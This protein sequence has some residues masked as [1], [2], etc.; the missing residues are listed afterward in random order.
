VASTSGSDPMAR[1]LSSR[2]IVDLQ[3]PPTP[4]KPRVARRLARRHREVSQRQ[5]PQ[6]ATPPK[7]AS[8]PA[9]KP[10]AASADS[11]SAPQ[12]SSRTRRAPEKMFGAARVLGSHERGFAA[13]RV[14]GRTSERGIR[15]PGEWPW[16]VRR[17]G[18]L[19]R[20]CGCRS[21]PGRLPFS[22]DS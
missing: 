4:T 18:G 14:Q 2:G 19:G 11:P 22:G 13:S 8:V 12:R 10:S 5:R 20:R 6:P 7:P 9:R 15:G 21:L 16:A 17:A 3:V 1:C